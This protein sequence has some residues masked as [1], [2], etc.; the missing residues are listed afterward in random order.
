MT[1][2]NIKIFGLP[3]L[4]AMPATHVVAESEASASYAA[5]RLKTEVPTDTWRSLGYR[6]TK[7]SFYAELMYGSDLSVAIGVG[8][9]GLVNHNLWPWTGEVRFILEDIDGP[10]AMAD[11][12]E[13]IV[14]S[15][16][17][18]QTNSSGAVGDID[19]GLTD[20][21][22]V[23]IAHTLNAAPMS[24][25]FAMGNPSNNPKVGSRLQTIGVRMVTSGGS[26]IS[27]APSV[28][29]ELRN[30]GVTR[31]SLGTKVVSSTAGHWLWFPFDAALLSATPNGTACEVVVTTTNN[32]DTFSPVQAKVDKVVWIAELEGALL[33]ANVLADSGWVPAG[34]YIGNPLETTKYLPQ[35]MTSGDCIL[36]DFHGVATPQDPDQLIDREVAQVGN[37]RVLIR[38]DH[39]PDTEVY[40]LSSFSSPPPGYV[41]VGHI[42]GCGAV[43]TT[44]V[45]FS[46]G[47]LDG[48]R[49]LSSVLFTQGGSQY[50][51]RNGIL[52]TA[53]VDFPALKTT[54]KAF[55]TDRVLRRRGRSRP[56]AV[57]LV[58]GDVLESEALSF[59]ATLAQPENTAA[60]QL[61]QDYRRKMSLNLVEYR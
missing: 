26:N 12:F 25:Y 19:D 28:N 23:G 45:N 9:V 18:S 46:I 8:G 51:Q 54:E 15:S 57:S 2:G 60:T 56:L 36:F 43:F 11:L 44:E 61:I 40:N 5:S 20:V 16:I 39:S 38:E 3:D 53:Q 49:D 41:E 14:P 58:P 21:T 34:K 4:F 1:V 52:R 47:P 33:E 59:Y 55:I 35:E 31:G 27:V 42:I 32:N 30:G 48:V 17:I 29:V 22:G 6:M 10:T 13:I 7:T 50:G 37:L 24:Q